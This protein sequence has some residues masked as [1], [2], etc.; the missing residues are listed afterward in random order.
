MLAPMQGLTNRAVR[1]VLS[2]LSRPDVLFT[3][4]ARVRHGGDGPR[5]DPKDLRE[6]RA[7]EGGIPLV[8][9]LIGREAGPL[10]E[11]AGE[12]Q[13]A[14]AAHLDLNLGCPF[15]RMN[16]GSGG[17]LLEHPEALASLL[18]AL[19]KAI[20]GSFSVKV[21]SGHSDPEQIFLLLP[22]FEDAGVDFLVLHPRTVVQQYEGQADHAITARVVAATRLPVI[23]NG[24]I[25][26]AEEGRRVLEQ[27]RAA[28]L[29]VGRGALADPL[30]FSR[31]RGQ[32]AAAP[33]P[34]ERAVLVRRLLSGVL[35]RYAAVYC[36]EAQALAKLGA[37]LT[38]LEA[39]CPG[40]SL[41][42]RRLKRAKSLRAFQDLLA[43][44]A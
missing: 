44:L 39:C 11:A 33:P 31:L 30:L 28:G 3:E 27:T 34:A 7:D 12:A 6:A 37:L 10:V 4:F 26:T 43:G 2:G 15:G 14:G 1:E 19:R 29:M 32:A 21:R 16:V 18:P 36:G 42:L 40:W 23:A 22:L 24:D 41:P 35:Q 38:Q 5:L 25:R 13:R 17:A 20:A 9:Q 8:V